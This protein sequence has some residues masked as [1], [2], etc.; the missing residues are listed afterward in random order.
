MDECEPLLLGL[1]PLATKSVTGSVVWAMSDGRG[2]HSLPFQLKL[3]SSIHRM[4]QV[5]S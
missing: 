1:Y 3:S 5:K 2:F 4:T